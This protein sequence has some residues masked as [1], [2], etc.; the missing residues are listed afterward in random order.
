MPIVSVDDVGD[1]A[2]QRDV[3][4]PLSADE[5]RWLKW[6]LPADAP[7]VPFFRRWLRMILDDTALSSEQVHDLLLAVG[8]AVSNAIEHAGSRRVPAST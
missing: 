1:R 7:S 4:G 6:S 3:L 8:E 2:P 5:Y